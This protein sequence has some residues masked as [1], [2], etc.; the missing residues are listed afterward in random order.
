[1]IQPCALALA[2]CFCL[3]STQSKAQGALFLGPEQGL[4]QSINAFVYKDSRGFIWISSV[5]GLNRFDG[6]RVRVFRQTEKDSLS[7]YGNNIQSPFFEDAQGDLWFATDL[8][9]NCYRRCKGHFEHFFIKNNTEHYAFHLDAS[10]KLWGIC[11]GRYFSFDTQNRTFELIG[12]ATTDAI[13]AAFLPD[14]L[15][16]AFWEL[17]PGVE[18]LAKGQEAK[19]YFSEKSPLKVMDVQALEAGQLVLGTNKGLLL[20]PL[21][22]PDAA[23]LYPFPD[24]KGAVLSIQVLNPT[25]LLV[26][27]V[28]GKALYFDLFS[29]QYEALKA[30]ATPEIPAP[31]LRS[32]YLD[33]DNILWASDY[34]NGVFF[35]SQQAL[36]LWQM[37]ADIA[38]LSFLETRQGKIRVLDKSGKMAAFGSG[39]PERAQ[40]FPPFS[41]FFR[42]KN[43]EAGMF[44]PGQPWNAPGPDGI[45][46]FAFPALESNDYYLAPISDTQILAGT[47][48]GLYLLDLATLNVSSISTCAYEV[49]Q[50]SVDHLG[51]IWVGSSNFAELFSWNKNGQLQA[52]QRFENTGIVNQFAERR[53][54]RFMYV[55]TSTGLY[56]IDNQT[57]E[58]KKYDEQSGL[59]NPFVSA[60]QE[61]ARGCL[62]LTTNRGLQQFD[63]QDPQPGGRLFG[64]REGL[65]GYAFLPGAIF[66]DSKG[67]IWLGGSKGLD[68]FHPDSMRACGHAP[69]PALT[70]LYIHD[71][72]WAGDT[73]IEC[74]KTLELAHNE[75]TLRLELA[76]LELLDPAANQFKVQLQSEA[77][78][79]AA[80]TE[81]GTQPFVTYANL[82]PGKYTFR[83]IAANAEGLWTPEMEAR[84][85]HIRIRPHWSQ[86]WQFM[87]AVAFGLLGITVLVL[88]FYYRYRLR[89]QQLQAEKARREAETRQLQ[90]ENELAL[91]QQRNRIA[92]D[93]HDE[94]GS[95]ISSISIL[96]DAALRNLQS[97]L[98]RARL[99]VI[100]ERA[101]QVMEA[102]SDI[103]WSVN[104]R[105]DTLSSVLQ[106]MKEFAVEI[107]EPQ[108]IRLH[109]VVEGDGAEKAMTMEQR[110]DFYLLFKEA[111]NNAAKYSGAA[112]LW[113]NIAPLAGKTQMR[114]RDDGSGF[115]QS[116]FKPGNGL[117][118]MQ[119]RA[120]RLG[121]TL[122]IRAQAGVGTEIVLTL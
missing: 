50:L 6:R 30:M 22:Q 8:A 45:R 58:V 100:G 27:G 4:S 96:S 46:V 42:L 51:R 72:P 109:F 76:A 63:P 114:I 38:A 56:Q 86:T 78:A 15:A 9:I 97:E 16:G 95:T 118:N 70:G 48:T 107:L 116:N 74:L 40:T 88:R 77:D 66:Q 21:G 35:Q 120:E 1:M 113:V 93:L 20:F 104:P 119:R 121:G 32:A 71:Q 53:D 81:L 36:P 89:A 23:Q 110:K 94:L 62:W 84:V 69:V 26:L 79:S 115:D 17:G 34:K 19:R 82:A 102:V 57:F 87:L 85:L 98:D 44:I 112:N 41:Q 31:V 64:V 105:N 91:E 28:S 61:D 14:A 80:W 83:L 101:R 75:N 12:A 47:F 60:V 3:L 7:L 92:R 122:E 99:G 117:W 73:A 108:D 25:R 68:R 33:R 11:A 65:S 24:A 10:G 5:D 29:R 90:L 2:L 13:R 59:A 54:G 37:A 43:G 52:L 103:V 49:G 18:V 106:K 67:Y 111:V 39:K 55:A